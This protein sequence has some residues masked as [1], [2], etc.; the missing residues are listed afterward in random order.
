MFAEDYVKAFPEEKKEEVKETVNTGLTA[1]EVKE[2]LNAMKESMLKEVQEM[3]KN[4]NSAK[5]D[6]VIEEPQKLEE[7]EGE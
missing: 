7:K 1:S 6:E 3:I 2:Y 4:N 5:A